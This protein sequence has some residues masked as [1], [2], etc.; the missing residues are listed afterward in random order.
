MHK[1]LKTFCCLCSAALLFG[2][3]CKFPVQSFA[4]SDKNPSSVF[5]YMD[6]NGYLDECSWNGS[7]AF[8]N[9]DYDGDGLTDRVFRKQKAGNTTTCTYRIEFG[10]G[11]R[12]LLKDADW[13]GTPVIQAGD[14]D[15]DGENEI[16]FTQEYFMSTDPHG[17][18]NMRLY[19][20]KGKTYKLVKLPLSDSGSPSYQP[21]LTLTYQIDKDH[22]YWLTVAETGYKSRF[23]FT[24]SSLE[25]SGM[26]AY[27]DIFF[28]GEK[29]QT[30]VYEAK[31]RHNKKRTDIL[32]RVSPLGKF[33]ADEIRFRIVFTN[34]G[35]V[36][37]NMKHVS[38]PYE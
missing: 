29:Y 13:S 36:I 14:T 24:R 35:Y 23:S 7:K 9:C 25:E 4:K 22:T 18:G 6:Y 28:D 5:G 21:G 8:K 27:Y 15:H 38:I 33:C 10:N 34:H 26:T 17:F 37:K 11:T 19:D 3:N 16:L 31:L 20:P 30:P 12:L 32:C 1:I 2:V